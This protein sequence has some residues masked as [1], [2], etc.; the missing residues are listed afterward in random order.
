MSPPK[1]PPSQGSAAALPCAVYAVCPAQGACAVTRAELGLCPLQGACGCCQ[2]STQR[3]LVPNSPGV[4]LSLGPPG[5][6][7][8]GDIRCNRL[9][10]EPALRGGCGGDAGPASFPSMLTHWLE[11]P[12]GQ[13]G[14]RL[15]QQSVRPSVSTRAHGQAVTL[16]VYLQGAGPGRVGTG[17][18]FSDGFAS[19]A[20]TAGGLRPRHTGGFSLLSVKAGACAHT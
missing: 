1:C 11:A 17:P 14:L 12:V 18:G 19:A 3:A 4:Q 20:R 8:Q 13:G 10:G 9:M 15:Q 7:R 5:R 6:G 2:A 16:W